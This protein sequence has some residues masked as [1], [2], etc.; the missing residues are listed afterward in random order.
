MKRFINT[1]SLLNSLKEG[2]FLF[3]HDGCILFWNEGATKI[4]GF[5]QPE[6]SG[7]S[8]YIVFRGWTFPWERDPE[9]L[10]YPVSEFG[11]IVAVED[12]A[13]G[14][15][16]LAIEAVPQYDEDGTLLGGIGTFHDVTLKLE[17]MALAQRIQATM[18]NAQPSLVGFALDVY[19][20]PEGIVGGDF[21]K[22]HKLSESEYSL[23]YGDFTGH[24]IV[25]A[26]YTVMMD[27]HLLELQRELADPL[28]MAMRLNDDLSKLLA[29]G[30]FCT[31][32]VGRLDADSGNFSF[33][34][35]GSPPLMHIRSDGSLDAHRSTSPPLG[36]FKE[37]RFVLSHISLH[38][39]ESLFFF[40]DGLYEAPNSE[41]KMIG[42]R[43]VNKVLRG[44]IAKGG[45]WRVRDLYAAL[46]HGYSKYKMRDDILLVKLTDTS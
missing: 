31:A 30:Y 34:Q 11:E 45:N 21:F 35:A 7:K 16:M 6:M 4:L 19:F 2:V 28:Q 3:D 9:M 33:V 36:L 46:K 42:L 12:K 27:K 13:G 26:M 44:M 24:G 40:S 41:G 15:K 29:P 8:V 38:Q 25:G 5:T 23:F 39:G 20:H 43:G 1:E 18:I 10:A 37:S 22:M 17:E 14:E 32:I